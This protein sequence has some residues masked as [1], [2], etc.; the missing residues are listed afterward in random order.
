MHDLAESRRREGPFLMKGNK[1]FSGASSYSG[2]SSEE[3]AKLFSPEGAGTFT[4]TGS[5]QPSRGALNGVKLL[6]I[7]MLLSTLLFLLFL[8]E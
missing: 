3:R 7:L 1:Q 8:V 5:R 6:L 2:H 4:D